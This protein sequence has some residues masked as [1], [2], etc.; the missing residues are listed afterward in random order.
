MGTRPEY[1]GAAGAGR[2]GASGAD[3]ERI[4]GL[5]E[6]AFTEGL[7]TKD[8]FVKLVNSALTARTRGEKDMVRADIVIAA[9]RTGAWARIRTPEGRPEYRNWA[10]F[11]KLAVGVTQDFPIRGDAR[12]S[13]VAALRNMREPA[14][15]TEIA[16]AT[17]YALR[18]IKYDARELRL[19]N[20]N[21][22]NAQSRPR[23]GSEGAVA[24]AA[25]EG[26][27]KVNAAMAKVNMADVAAYIRAKVPPAELANLLGA[28]Y[29]AAMP[30]R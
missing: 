2:L 5:L 19:V 27:E 30:S 6:A 1:Q 21:R 28:E 3:R 18:T 15:L 23:D 24:K 13:V 14:E 26:A 17:G 11:C 29:V 16:S 4:A 12:K 7:L 10:E 20:E 8:E 22:S 25:A 9:Y